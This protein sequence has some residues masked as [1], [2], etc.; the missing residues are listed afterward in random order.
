[1]NERLQAILHPWTSF[2]IVPVFALANA[3]VDLRDGVLQDALGSRVM[4]GVV[5]GLVAGKPIGIAILAIAGSRLRLGPVPRGLGP[6]QLL[7]GGALSGMGFSVSILIVNL[8]F[9]SETLRE[10]ATVGVLIA[11]ALSVL[12]GWLAFQMGRLGTQPQARGQ[13]LDPAVD[14]QRDHVLDGAG[15]PLTLVEYGDFECPFCGTATHVVKDLRH[16]YEGQLRYV[17]RHLPLADVH[18]H[19]ELAAEASE[20]AAAQG[21]FWEMHDLLF[22]RHDELEM[23]DLVGYAA[24]LGLDVEQFTRALTEGRYS[25]RVRD[26]VASAEASGARSTPTFFVNGRRHSGPWNAEALAAVL[27]SELAATEQPA[28]QPGSGSTPE[29]AG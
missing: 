15:A 14:L 2:V 29:P 26:D 21:K 7:G 8:A 23:E 19:S 3:G 10:Q 13:V 4:W 18:P 20:A 11:C 28:V 22:D 1:V 17:F 27:D 12:T 25:Q 5:L 16:R 6:W 9:D 24:E